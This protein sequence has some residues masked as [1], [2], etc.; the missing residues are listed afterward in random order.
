MTPSQRWPNQTST[1]HAVNKVNWRKIP[2][3]I[4]GLRPYPACTSI[5]H[6]CPLWR[7]ER[8]EKSATYVLTLGSQRLMADRVCENRFLEQLGNNVK[9]VREGNYPLSDAK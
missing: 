9:D 8:L 1:C 5:L 2:Q 7:I 4:L 6:I 3:I